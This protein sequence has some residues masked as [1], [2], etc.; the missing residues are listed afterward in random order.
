MDGSARCGARPRA[1]THLEL[2]VRPAPSAS[3]PAHR[4]S[5]RHSLSAS[6]QCFCCRF[7]PSTK[8]WRIE[9][10]A[11]LRVPNI[12]TCGSCPIVI[13]THISRPTGWWIRCV[14]RPSGASLTTIRRYSAG[15]S[16]L[17]E[18]T[19]ASEMSPARASH[20][21]TSSRSDGESSRGGNVSITAFGLLGIG[22]SL[23]SRMFQRGCVAITMMGTGRAPDDPPE[24][25]TAP[26]LSC[27]PLLGSSRPTPQRLTGVARWCRLR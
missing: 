3:S 9:F 14:G 4:Q 16:D 19:W 8:T 15:S 23:P 11:A 20:S 17:R 12:S 22:R 7:P 26:R 18:L 27:A 24:R 21:R 1:A 13:L 2:V 10:S 5:V 6:D 25:A